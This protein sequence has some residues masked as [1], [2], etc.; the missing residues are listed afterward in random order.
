MQIVSLPAISHH[1]TN[2]CIDFLK[3]PRPAPSSEKKFWENTAARFSTS[4]KNMGADVKDDFS[5]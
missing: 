5:G 3:S 1:H 4:A 2:G